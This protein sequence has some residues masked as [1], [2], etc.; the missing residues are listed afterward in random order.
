MLAIYLTLP[1]SQHVSEEGH[2]T[3]EPAGDLTRLATARLISD[4]I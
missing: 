3:E 2:Y 1:E 4:I